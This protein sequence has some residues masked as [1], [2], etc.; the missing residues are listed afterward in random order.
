M[1]LAMIES[2]ELIVVVAVI[3]L[4]FGTKRIPDLARSLGKAKAEFH[5]GISEASADQP[6]ENDAPAEASK[7]D[8]AKT[9]E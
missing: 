2:W 8:T 4:L 9:G 3:A 6:A 7:T 1:V 5:Q